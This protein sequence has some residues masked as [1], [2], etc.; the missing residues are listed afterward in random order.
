WCAEVGQRSPFW[1]L[2]QDLKA[3]LRSRKVL[4]VGLRDA[5]RERA[6]TIGQHGV[7]PLRHFRS[8]ARNRRRGRRSA[9]ARCER[10]RRMGGPAR[11]EPRFPDTLGTSMAG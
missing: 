10:L 4:R 7:L 8:A 9:P 1:G 11:A 2:A 3:L 5:E 6:P